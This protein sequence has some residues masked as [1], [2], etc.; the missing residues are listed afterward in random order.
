MLPSSDHQVGASLTDH[1]LE[2]PRLARSITTR[3]VDMAHCSHAKVTQASASRQACLRNRRCNLAKRQM[4]LVTIISVGQSFDAC[5]ARTFDRSNLRNWLVKS[6][7]CD[8]LCRIDFD[9]VMDSAISICSRLRCYGLWL[10]S[11]AASLQI[12]G[13]RSQDIKGTGR[14]DRVVRLVYMVGLRPSRLAWDHRLRCSG[15][16]VKTFVGLRAVRNPVM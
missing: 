2:L 4:F 12:P 8:I 16:R 9:I 15:H 3:L 1:P 14:A 13:D 5:R 10:F 11:K 7:Y 6:F